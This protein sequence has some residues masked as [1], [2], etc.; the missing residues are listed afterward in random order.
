MTLVARHAALTDIGLH[1]SGNEDAFVDELPLFAVADGMGGAQAGEIASHLALDSLAADLAAGATLA[2]A[3]QAANETRL[4]RV[5][6]RPG[7]QPAW[8][9]PSPPPC[10]ATTASSSPTSATAASTCGA[11]RPS[12]RSPTTTRWSARWCARAT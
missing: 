6:L 10:W 11:T 2:H 12:T 7:A 1:R 8:A 5:A 9:P 4:P 3:A